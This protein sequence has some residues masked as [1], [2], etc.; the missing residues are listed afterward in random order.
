MNLREN[1]KQLFAI[2]GL[3]SLVVIVAFYFLLWSPIGKNISSANA[4][5]TSLNSQVSSASSKITSLKAFQASLPIAQAEMGRLDI[6]IPQYPQLSTFIESLNAISTES[7]ITFL[8]ITSGQ[9]VTQA[10]PTP[11]VLPLP[12]QVQLGI[13]IQGG[14]FQVLDFLNRLDHL[15]RLVVST[16][17]NLTSN[18]GQAQSSA[19]GVA[20]T[21]AVTGSEISGSIKASIYS[22]VL[23]AGVPGTTTT[24]TPPSTT[25]TAVST[26]ATSTTQPG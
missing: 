16:S 2:A 24:T 19:G 14:Y 1:R 9:P 18:S 26:G 23:P 10:T 20:G 5:L 11:G 4:N 22:Q 17:V 8:S 15:P 21:S 3:F 12:P 13:Q 6:A 7:G 25:T